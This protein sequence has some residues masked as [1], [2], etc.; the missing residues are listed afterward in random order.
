M[1]ILKIARIHFIHILRSK[2]LNLLFAC[3][4]SFIFLCLMMVKIQ[5]AV[6]HRII[7]DF[8]LAMSHLFTLMMAIILGVSDFSKCC[9]NKTIYF[10][11]SS[12]SKDT[13]LS[14]RIAGIAFYL[15]LSQ[16][17]FFMATYVLYYVFGGI[18]NFLH[19]WVYIFNLLEMLILLLLAFQ[20]SLWLSKKLAFF[21]GI[22]FY[23][24]GVTLY[25]NQEFWRQQKSLFSTKLGDIFSYII[26]QFSRFN[27]RDVILYQEKIP[28]TYLWKT[29]SY[30]LGFI[31]ILFL[32]NQIIFKY[33]E[34]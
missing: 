28:L 32:L 2:F 27:L 19:L 24:A 23:G 12:Y 30:G 11:L 22:I 25:S 4:I 9:E 17:C 26:P 3:L 31:L 1:D 5:Y 10:Y 15:L 34:I 13:F 8:G 20:F 16:A 7:L 6:P 29:T 14:A 21:S 18:F 33:K